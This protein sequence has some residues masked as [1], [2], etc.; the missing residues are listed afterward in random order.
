MTRVLHVSTVDITV[1][2]LLLPLLQELKVRGY[3]VEAACRIEQAP[4]S[5][6][7]R[8]I[9][10]HHIGGFA[11]EISPAA[12]VAALGQLYELMRR[13]RYD[14]VH[15][16]TPKANFYGRLA[17]RM[18]GVPVVIGM[19]HGF[20]FYNMSG[21][22]RE[23]HVTLARLG[24]LASDR[25]ITINHEDYEL[26]LREKIIAPERLSVMPT[27][28]GVDLSRFRPDID[29]TNIRAQLG[30]EG[31]TLIGSVGRLTPEKGCRELIDAAARVVQVF[32][33]ACFL[34]VGPSEN[35]MQSELEKTVIGLGLEKKVRFL[36]SRQDIPQILSALDVFVLPSYREGLSMVLLEAAATGKPSVSTD[37]RGCRDVVV[38]GETGLL[39]PPRD[40]PRLAEAIIELLRDSAKRECMGMAARRRAEALFDARLAFAQIEA[41][42]EQLLRAR[43]IR[44]P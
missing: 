10:L 35:Q 7:A 14:I 32:P 2:V 44:R 40:A 27:G 5:F 12:D 15:T 11:R 16:H 43:G 17:A 30:L 38:H 4:S 19:E 31:G 22:R 13:R 28:L 24:A 41:I 39:V 21:I 34:L 6:V 37:V 8:D 20:Y 26:A 9:P 33:D 42:Y 36:G 23:F 3:E 29:R 25:T 18:A 1:R